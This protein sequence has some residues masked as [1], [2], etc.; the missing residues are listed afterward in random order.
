MSDGFAVLLQD[1]ICLQL[2]SKAQ[3]AKKPQNTRKP[4][5]EKPAAEKNN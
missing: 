2:C 1:T 4:A 5:K 3:S